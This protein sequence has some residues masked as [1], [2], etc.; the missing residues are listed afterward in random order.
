MPKKSSTTRLHYLDW[1]RGLGTVIML[2]GHVFDSFT[3]N[4]L[5][6]GGAFVYSQFVGGMPPTIFLFLTGVTLA[7][8]MDSAQRKGLGPGAR[9]SAALRRAAYLFAIAF[10]FRVQLW[11]FGWP[12]APWTDLLKVDILNCMGFGIAILSV[13]GLFTAAQRI[14]VCAFLGLAIAFASP[15]VSQMD[16]SAL[17]PMLRSYIVPDYRYF[18][19]FPWAAYLAFGMSAGSVLRAL[20]EDGTERAMQ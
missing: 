15:V 8:L 5:R 9:V 1:V 12:G 20:P 3:R 7:F 16:W 18:G 10:A 2:Q 14:R 4:D 6:E 13:I 17:P 19:F 11:I